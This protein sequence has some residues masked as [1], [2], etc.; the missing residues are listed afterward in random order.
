MLY[1]DVTALRYTAGRART[2]SG[3][4]WKPLYLPSEPVCQRQ[5]QLYF[6]VRVAQQDSASKTASTV[7]TGDFSLTLSAFMVQ[8]SRRYLRN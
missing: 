2:H 6:E 7:L 5:K 3:A 1:S 4:V 8:N